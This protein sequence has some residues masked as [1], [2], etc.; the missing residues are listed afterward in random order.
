MGRLKGHVNV[1]LSHAKRDIWSP[2]CVSVQ[3]SSLRELADRL[4]RKLSRDKT[5]QIQDK[6][7]TLLQRRDRIRELSV[8]RREELQLSQLL[9]MFNRD[10]AEVTMS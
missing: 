2:Y 7:R 8:K 5:R 9:C 3:L 1:G 6:L 4:K 10:V